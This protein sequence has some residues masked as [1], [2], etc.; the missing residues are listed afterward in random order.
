MLYGRCGSFQ[1]ERGVFQGP[2]CS[3]YPLDRSPPLLAEVM[4]SIKHYG[5]TKLMAIHPENLSL[6]Y[7]EVAVLVFFC[8][9]NIAYRP[10]GS[11][12]F[13]AWLLKRRGLALGCAFRGWIK[14]N[15]LEVAL[16]PNSHT[17]VSKSIF[18]AE[19]FLTHMTVTNRRTKSQVYG[20]RLAGCGGRQNEIG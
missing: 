8:L 17:S 20:T 10:K 12:D 15:R 19:T 7:G 11:A 1:W 3:W 13:H 9:L 4:M 2:P 18:L 6:Q 14:K 16:S 5:R